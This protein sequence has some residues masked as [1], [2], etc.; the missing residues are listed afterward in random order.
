MV[1]SLWDAREL[2]GMSW[3]KSLFLVGIGYPPVH[4]PE[5]SNQVLDQLLENKNS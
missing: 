4:P 1:E 3:P 2:E 5:R